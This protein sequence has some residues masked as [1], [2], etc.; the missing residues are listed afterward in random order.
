MTKSFDMYTL[1]YDSWYNR[2]SKVFNAELAAIKKVLGHVHPENRC[3]EVGVGTG[4]F[5]EA[6][7]ITYGVDPSLEMLKFA[8]ERDVSCIQAVAEIL[9]FKGTS[10][11]VILMVTVVCFLTDMQQTFAE[12]YRTLKPGGRLILGMIDRN[13]ELGKAY[14]KKQQNNRYYMH[15]KF[16]SVEEICTRMHEAGLR[17]FTTVQTLFS[18]LEMI[19][20]AE[21]V[22]YGHGEGGF[23][24]IGAN[25]EQI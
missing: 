8:R 13:S 7:H 21:P 24:V 5:A 15:A 6:L 2:R 18:S 11:D 9:P 10:F 20:D 25:K 22:I 17:N 19:E 12:V 4:R 1:E 23:V 16:S 14:L 3:I